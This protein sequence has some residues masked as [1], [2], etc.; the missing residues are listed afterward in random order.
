M[1]GVSTKQRQS[2]NP[3]GNRLMFGVSFPLPHKPQQDR[4]R[5]RNVA[6]KNQERHCKA[7]PPKHQTPANGNKHQTSNIKHQ[8]NSKLQT[9]HQSDGCVD[10]LAKSRLPFGVWDLVF[11]WCLMFDV[12]CFDKAASKFKSFWQ[13]FDVWC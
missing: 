10:S 3:F 11:C 12:W 7:P 5:N 1:F 13:P 9:P 6:N 4:N 8:I 2:S